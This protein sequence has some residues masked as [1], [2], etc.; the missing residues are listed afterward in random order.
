M[1]SLLRPQKSGS[2]LLETLLSVVILSTSLTVIIQS[3][4]SSARSIKAGHEYSQA[5]LVLENEMA[6]T[7]RRIQFQEDMVRTKKINE[8]EMKFA[9]EREEGFYASLESEQLNQHDLTLEW[10][11]GKRN[12]RIMLSTLIFEKPPTEEGF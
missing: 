4:M 5:L 9:V 8:G 10:K 11:T 7:I 6:D 3:L 2:I 12:N 1:S